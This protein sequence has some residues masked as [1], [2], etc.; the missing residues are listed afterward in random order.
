MS[1]LSI[2]VLRNSL[3]P[4]QL[5]FANE[6]IKSGNGADS[7][8]RAG[9]SKKTA[10]KTAS[11]NLA[12]EPIKKYIQAVMADMSKS[13]IASAEEIQE[14]WTRCLRREEYEDVLTDDG[15]ENER[16][17]IKDALKASELLAKVHGI[18]TDKQETKISGSIELQNLSEL[19]T[20]TLKKL[21][22]EKDEQFD[23]K[24]S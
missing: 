22:D 9:Y 16:I 6:Y 7:A 8:I 2:T 23:F 12:K 18:L 11:V 17:S 24:D 3:T 20:E 1:D 13:K 21:A 19:P 15:I 4:K 5:K 10:R 14:M